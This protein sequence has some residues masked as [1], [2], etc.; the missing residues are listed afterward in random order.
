[1]PSLASLPEFE[2][3]IP[4]GIPSGEEVR[5][6]AALDDA[7]ALVR[8]VAEKTWDDPEV[9]GPVPDLVKMVVMSAARRAYI[10]PDGVTQESIDGAS[11]SYGSASPDVYLTA[12][13][14]RRVRAAVGLKPAGVWTL[15]TTREDPVGV[16]DVRSIY[17]PLDPPINWG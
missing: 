11:T 16:T 3:R 10:N 9:D 14:E 17:G 8:D 7:S 5:A 6:Q 13:E 15:S 1:M 4:G 12:A 2:A